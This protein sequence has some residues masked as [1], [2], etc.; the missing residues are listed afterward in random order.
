MSG[1]QP[2]SRQELYERIRKSSKDEVVLEEMIRL[3]FWPKQAALADD[4]ADEIRRRGELEAELRALRTEASRL[5]DIEA[6]KREARK[7]RLEESRRKRE[8]NKQRRLREREER[9]AA[10]AEKQKTTIGYLGKGVSA[11]LN[12][13]ESDL[14]KLARLEIPRLA[15]AAELAAAM[16]ITVNELRFLAFARGT[17]KV[18]HYVQ[19]TIPKRSGGVRLISAPMERLKRAQHWILEHMLERQWMHDAAHGFRQGRSIVSNARPH[20]GADVVINLDLKDF[21]P[22][23]TY[24]RVKGLFRSFGYSESVATV[25]AL[26][27][28]EPREVT[29]D[30]DGER[31]HVALT[32]RFLPQ[33]APTSPAISNLLCRA[34]DS[35]LASIAEKLG[36]QYTRYADDLTFSG[37]RESNPGRLMRRIHWVVEHEGF[38]V[39]PDKTR[40]LRKSRRQEV[41][42]VVVNETCTISRDTLKKFRAVLFQ[43]EKD[44]PE[45][46]SWGNTP[47]V[48]AAIEGFANYVA[49]VNPEK[50]T[51]LQAQ[52][53]ALVNRY[54][55]KPQPKPRR[56]P[57]QGEAAATAPSD[58]AFASPAAAESALP[59]APAK[60]KPWWKLW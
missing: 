6:M 39:H 11:G 31:Y 38:T 30:V 42:G 22:T 47:D 57:S 32:E 26:L 52:A 58:E 4:P 13:A 41:T 53:Q 54:G 45:G 51:P 3:G 35:R 19:F 5:Q 48:I 24:K 8:E 1:T 40:V 2:S 33:G 17:S 29:V 20:V 59:S 56:K 55:K 43:I 15:N 27:C 44:G 36:Y 49:M 46:K 10:W 7:R 37:P 25:C 9:K 23:V 34:L 18:T 50:G 14:E 12:G 60:K 28:T 16:G 21:F